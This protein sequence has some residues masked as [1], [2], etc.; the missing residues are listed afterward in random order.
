MNTPSTLTHPASNAQS[1]R[2]KVRRQVLWNRL[3]AVV[4]EVAKVLLRNAFGAVTRDGDVFINNEP[5]CGT[6][7]PFDFVV[8]TLVFLDQR[9]VSFVASTRHVIDI[10]GRGFPADVRSAYEEGLW[11][12]HLH[13]M[14]GGLLNVTLQ[15]F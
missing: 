7:H 14:R 4:E 12:P 2:D 10:G 13:L 1:M 9:L 11:I 6:G 15:D 3:I 5:R 8:V